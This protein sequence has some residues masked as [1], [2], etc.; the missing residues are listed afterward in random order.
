[1]IPG[2]VASAIIGFWRMGVTPKEMEDEQLVD[3]NRRQIR[4]VIRQYELKLEQSQL[5]ENMWNHKEDIPGG[6][7][8]QHG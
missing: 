7:T 2:N 4:E 6:A 1:M 8:I 3:M 5:Y